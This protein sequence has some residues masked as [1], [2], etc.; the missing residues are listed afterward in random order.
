MRTATPHWSGKQEDK[1]TQVES[2]HMLEIAGKIPFEL[3]SV[4]LAFFQSQMIQGVTHS[5]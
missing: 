3:I 1:S 2:T 5:K 4:S